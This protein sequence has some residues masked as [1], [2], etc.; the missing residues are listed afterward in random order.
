MQ[1]RMRLALFLG[2]TLSSL[3]LPQ[4]VHGQLPPRPQVKPDLPPPTVANKNEHPLFSSLRDVINQG[5]KLFN[6]KGDHAGCYR[7]FQGALIAVRPYL[8][9]KPD[10]LQHVDKSLQSAESLP[11]M[12]DRAFALRMVLDSIRDAYRVPSPGTDPGPGPGPGPGPKMPLETIPNPKK[13]EKVDEKPKGD[14]KKDDK[15]DDPLKINQTRRNSAPSF[16]PALAAAAPALDQR[17]CL[18]LLDDLAILIEDVPLPGNDAA[19]AS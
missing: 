15:K 10:L 11:R 5:A 14:I 4:A 3:T 9:D 7:V 19:P 16:L 18:A 13:L 2:L 17:Q 1:N 12:V 6:E 8:K